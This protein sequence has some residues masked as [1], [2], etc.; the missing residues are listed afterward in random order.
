MTKKDPNRPLWLEIAVPAFVS[1]RSDGPA[2]TEMIAADRVRVNAPRWAPTPPDL[3]ARAALS[4][5]HLLIGWRRDGVAGLILRGN[6]IAWPT[7]RFPGAYFEKTLGK[8]MGRG[9][10]FGYLADEPSPMILL[11]DT[12]DDERLELSQAR[13]TMRKVF[14]ALRALF[15]A[16]IQ[17]T[18]TMIEQ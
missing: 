3:L 4:S 16:G 8:G 17:D 5:S 18:G 15:P 1:V 13:E 11:A 9:I 14:Q 2:A 10:V 7:E 12:A 6:A